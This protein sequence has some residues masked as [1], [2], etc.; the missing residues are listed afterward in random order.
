M[1]FSQPK[2]ENPCK[3]FY[4]FKGDTGV[5]KRWNK[6]KEEHE[7]LKTP[8]YFIVLDQLN[9]IKGYSDQHQCGIYSNEVHSLTNE[10]LKVKSFKGG[11]SI[12]GLYNEIKGEIASCG[13]KFAKSVYCMKIDESGKNHELVNFQFVGAALSSWFDFNKSFSANNHIVAI[14]GETEEGKKGRVTYFM[15][16]FKRFNMK[17][18]YVD[19]ATSMD[20][21]LQQY[22][23]DYKSNTKEKEIEVEAEILTDA[24]ILHEHTY[25]KDKQ[26][27]YNKKLETSEVDDDLPF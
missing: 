18:E 16:V 22:L 24:E 11:L 25:E 21:M 9:T 14:T 17:D 3:K 26:S 10:I 27:V 4:E 2:K 12:T 1:S 8:S 23:F 13:G 5:F 15:P 19:A 20:K 7:E 6:E